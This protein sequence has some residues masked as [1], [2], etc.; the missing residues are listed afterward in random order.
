MAETQADN[1]FFPAWLLH[2]KTCAAQQSLPVLHR[3]E[4]CRILNQGLNKKLSLVIGPAGYGKSTLLGDW[5]GDLQADGIAAGWLNLDEQDSD[6]GLF[7]LYLAYSL[8]EAGLYEEISRLQP[9][10][11]SDNTKPTVTIGVLLSAIRNYDERIVLILDGVENLPEQCI[12]QILDPVLLYMPDNLHLVLAGRHC[13]DLPLSRLKLQG[14]VTEISGNDLKFTPFE[15]EEFLD[16]YLE[17]KDIARVA[18]KL[19][20]WPA[21][22]QLVRNIL[23]ENSDPSQ[24]LT[25]YSGAEK[26]TRDYIIETV[27][28]PLSSLQKGLLLD[29][30][31]FEN[32]DRDILQDMRPEGDVLAL[33]GTLNSLDGQFLYISGPAENSYRIH[34]LLREALIS[35]LEETNPAH[36]REIHRKAAMMY[37]DTGDII[38][39]IKHSLKAGTPEIGAIAVEKAGGVMLWNKEGMSRIRQ[40]VALLPEEVYRDHPRLHLAKALVCLKDGHLNDGRHIFD[41][42][43]RQIEESG[44][45]PTTELAYDLVV[46]S[47]T[48]SVYDG[49]PLTE[50]VTDQ[51]GDYINNSDLIDKVQIGFAQTVV[52]ISSLQKGD[53]E[54]AKSVGAQAVAHFQKYNSVFGEVYIYIHMASV[55]LAEGELDEAQDYLTKVQNNQRKYFIDDKDMRLVSS[56]LRAEL[57]YER[58]ELNS[59]ARLLKDINHRLENGEAWY[60][61]YASGYTVST[62]LAFLTKGLEACLSLADESSKYIKREGLKRLN[63][64]VVANKAGYLCRS[65]L[66]SK[67]RKL[68]QQNNLTFEEY[69]RN[70]GEEFSA[71]EKYGVLQAL[72]RLLIAEK[73]YDEAI[74]ELRRLIQKAR[75]DRHPQTEQKYRLFLA[76]AGFESGQKQPAFR[77]L[78]KV[79]SFVRQKGLLRFML[80]E[81]SFVLPLLSAYC[82]DAKAAER[83][84][85]RYILSCVEETAPAN[86][87]I[88]LTRRENQM[89]E[90]I[91][92]GHSDK[93]IARNLGVSENTVRFHLKNL[94]KKLDVKNRRL[95]VVEAKRQLLLK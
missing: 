17:R 88:I 49:T 82:E 54:T 56:I 67:A 6:P 1:A 38:Q 87:K 73:R 21:A 90:Q 72:M 47:S 25:S 55:A 26:N 35:H 60:E 69:R 51:I 64:L 4:L 77:E 93:I 83:D 32:I 76:I 94:F 42:V 5:Y 91:A 11:F 7:A 68:I 36:F 18:E 66:V 29:F 34:P 70:H 45:A 10:G 2:S 52:C 48:L 65:D 40:A 23:A 22:V 74:P 92:E 31:I 20:G 63:R 95:A 78:D 14:Q 85:A 81:A 12:E 80:D 9:E 61:I 89:L 71:R 57:H 16:G 8:A 58:N 3:K 50:Q 19:E 62:A 39:A 13:G 75:R 27:F 79:L 24:A 59:A 15:I 84:H 43:T 33:L 53:Y 37:S 41:Q 30:C 44:T 46:I 28:S 86:D